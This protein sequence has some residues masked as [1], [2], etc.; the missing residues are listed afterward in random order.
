MQQ[1]ERK[2][3]ID[4]HISLLP[5][6]L[7][8]QVSTCRDV[9]SRLQA[10]QK[11][12]T[13]LWAQG[14]E[15]EKDATAKERTETLT[16]LEELQAAYE[17]A[18]QRSSQR[19]T[20]LEKA[21]TSRRYFQVDLDKICHWL[22][23]ADAITFPAINFSSAD[24]G[25][26][27]QKQLSDFQGVLEQTSEYE[28]LL[29]IVQRIGQEILPTLNEIDHCYLDERLNA[30]P[31]Q[32]NAILALAKE[33]K[34]RI[35]KIISERKD[36][37]TFFDITRNALEELQEQFDNLEKQTISTRE[38]E[39]IGVLNEFRRI[40]ESLIRISPAVRE[41]HGKS[42]GFLIKGQGYREE[43]TREMVCLHSLL[44]RRN[45]QKIKDLNDYLKTL[46]EQNRVLSKTDSELKSVEEDFAQLK[47]DK[48]VDVSDKITGLYLLLESL[49]G[50]SSQV[51][52]T[53]KCPLKFDPNTFQETTL[54]QLESSESLCNEIKSLIEECEGQS[55]FSMEAEGTSEWLVSLK[56]KLKEPLKMSE[57]RTEEI[58]KELS[59][60]KIMMEHVKSKRKA[61]DV[62]GVREK[63]KCESSKAVHIEE[64]L[65]DLTKLGDEVQEEIHAKQVCVYGTLFS[66]ALM[67]CSLLT[68]PVKFPVFEV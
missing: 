25:S 9:Q 3:L 64:K 2:A 17:S 56:D 5:E 22:G 43:E 24:E 11:E 8:R 26:D 31:Q 51:H 16:R 36:F 50:V 67:S 37:S 66:A 40:E 62:L 42:E 29:L 65:Q 39:V 63:Q 15:L 12:L 27:L 30:L 32:Y 54:L 23:Q 47:S 20:D 7:T 18:L 48:N 4:D 35:Q 33:K 34:D 57:V 53:K 59:R 1:Q 49:D 60:L 45:C 68:C 61:M 10:Y 14:R 21:L 13:S 55:D 19:L 6:D 58:N 41:L 52:P 38:E 28:N 46:V 44:K